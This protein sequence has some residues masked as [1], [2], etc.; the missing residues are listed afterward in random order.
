M[1]YLSDPMQ[2]WGPSRKELADMLPSPSI[3]E[4]HVCASGEPRLSEHA[5]LQFIGDLNPEASF[6]NNRHQHSDAPDASRYHDIGVW[7]ARRSEEHSNAEHDSNAPSL[8]IETQET[9]NLQRSGLVSLRALA[10]YLR[11]ECISVLPPEHEFGSIS[12]VFYSKFDVIF[13]V[14]HGEDLARHELME[15]T[16]LKQCICLMAALD[17]LSKNHLRLPHTESVLSPIDFR[18]CIAA[19]IKQSL[20]MSF[21]H[22]RMV[23]LQVCALMSFYADKSNSSEVSSNYCAQAVH[24][25][26]TLGLHLGWPETTQAEKSRRI[27]WC[28]RVLDRLNAATNGRPILMH[29]R[30]VDKRMTDAINE[31]LPSFRLLIRISD[32]L[33]AV[34]SQYRPHASEEAQA[35]H[36]VAFEDMAHEAGA[37]AIG[38]ALLASLELFYLAVMILRHRPS[39]RGGGD[40]RPT[41]SATQLFCS[42]TIVSL[43]SEELKRSLTFWAAVPYAVSLATSVAYTNLRTSKIPYKRKQAYSLFHSSCDALDELSTSFSSAQ[44]MARLA[45]DTLHEFERVAANRN[46]PGGH[47]QGEKEPIAQ[48]STGFSMGNSNADQPSAQ[49]LSVD[50]T[51]KFSGDSLPLAEG[52][53]DNNSLSST[54]TIIDSL[55]QD[56]LDFGVIP[57][58]FNSF[59]PEFGLDHID[60]VFSAN[61]N[62][63]FQP[64]LDGWND[65]D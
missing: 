4:L 46:K 15:R 53:G 24:H 33:E 62:S 21:I 36:E 48:I 26:H 10:P 17:P 14:L 6:L 7:Q 54:L 52:S 11:K 12:K 27:Y 35:P 60:A 2:V 58:I 55:Y 31:Q 5:Y 9:S 42:K 13:P 16:A 39:K 25:L 30:D 20:D 32:I 43:V 8:P 41:S 3:G 22:D 28:I 51:S 61:L 56:D 47:E 23:L 59:D 29:D 40:E 1:P 64:P 57:E 65:Y 63:G 49:A 18:R 50:M 37:L 44:T 38:S 34:I 45:K 19:A